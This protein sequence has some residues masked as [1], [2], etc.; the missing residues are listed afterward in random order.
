MERSAYLT[1]TQAERLA[2]EESMGWWEEEVREV[3][4][5]GC[6]WAMKRML[7]SE[8]EKRG[9]RFHPGSS[10]VLLIEALAHWGGKSSQLE[11][12][13][14]TSGKPLTQSLSRTFIEMSAALSLSLIVNWIFSSGTS[15]GSFPPRTLMMS[16]HRCLVGCVVRRNITR[17]GWNSQVWLCDAVL[18]LGNFESNG[19]LN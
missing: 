19:A 2:W 11:S 14:S 9:I 1:R 15:V 16:P 3:F 6:K 5:L 18:V 4:L 17:N 10:A 8:R 13:S 7:G 12:S